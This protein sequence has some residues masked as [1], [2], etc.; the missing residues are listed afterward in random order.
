MR[1]YHVT[2]HGTIYASI[3]VK[4]TV[5]SVTLAV[6]MARGSFEYVSL[7]I[8]VCWLSSLSLADNPNFL[9]R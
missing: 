5:S 8:T 3:N 9:L 2:A 4:T 7:M 6:G 1:K